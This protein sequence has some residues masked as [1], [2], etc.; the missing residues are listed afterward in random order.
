[1]TSE[2]R[3]VVDDIVKYDIDHLHA[4]GVSDIAGFAVEF[5]KCDV[6][7]VCRF[8]GKVLKG[9]SR[10]G[11]ILIC[12]RHREEHAAYLGQRAVVL[13][14]RTELGHRRHGKLKLAV[15]VAP[16]EKMKHVKTEKRAA[17]AEDLCV[18]REVTPVFLGRQRHLGAAD[19]EN[20][21]DRGGIV[22][23]I[24]DDGKTVVFILAYEPDAAAEAERGICSP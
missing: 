23:G 21:V 19:V 24:A 14:I 6:C 2:D 12:R 4:V 3:R 16:A 22:I 9:K 1:M 15:P 7:G 20:G 11:G 17:F 18:E 8:V 5:D 13:L 10:K